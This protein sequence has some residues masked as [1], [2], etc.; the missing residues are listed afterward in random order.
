VY[1]RFTEGVIQRIQTVEDGVTISRPENL[2][3]QHSYGLEFIGSTEFND[4]WKMNLSANFFR[5]IV[6]GGN[7]DEDLNADTYSWFS[8]LNSQ[9]ELP[10][11]IDLQLL[12]NYHAP[13]QTTQGR[14]DA[15]SYVDLGFVRE[16][17]AGQGTVSFK[18]ND[19]FNSRRYGGTTSGENFYI[20]QEYRR[21]FR[22][23]IFGFTYRLNK[24]NARQS[25]RNGMDR[26]NMEF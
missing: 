2:S 5:S 20:Q 11:N 8:R 22:Q 17:L 25:E 16:V 24:E 6:D 18:I 26:G 14:R 15:Y 9:M 1:Y 21:S 23:V 13:Y 4:W 19:L 10:A 3:T 12:V 7:L